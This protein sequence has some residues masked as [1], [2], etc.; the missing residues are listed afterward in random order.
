M[1]KKKVAAIVKIQIPAGAATPAPPVGTALGPHGIA[2]MDFCKAYNAADREPARHG[3]PGRDHDLRGPVVHL[4]HQDAA[5]GGA[6]PPGGGPREG[7]ANN[8]GQGTGRHDHRGPGRPRSPRPSCPTS[9]PTTST[10]PCSRSRAPPARWA[11][12]SPAD[13][14]RSPATPAGAP[15]DYDIT[16]PEHLTRGPDDEGV[17]HAA[18]Q[19][20]QGR[21]QSLR[22]GALHGATEAIDLVKSFASAKFDESIELAIQLGVDPRKPDQ[23]VRGT[24]SLPKGTGKTA[25]VAVFAQGDCRRGPAPPAPTSWAPTTSSPRS[26]AG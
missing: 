24:V 8:P 26:R 25:R 11:S 14:S 18:R 16:A 19:E 22:P 7:L 4:R 1:A 20:V 23:Q 9:T 15:V 5:D 17:D 21:A 12:R 13:R 6:A 3:R 10:P 2:I